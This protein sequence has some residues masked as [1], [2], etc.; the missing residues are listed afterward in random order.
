MY[1]V[2]NVPLDS[3][4]YILWV[5]YDY[6]YINDEEV[7]LFITNNNIIYGKNEKSGF[8][9]SEYK[10]Y[11]IN[12]DDILILNNMYKIWASYNENDELHCVKILLNSFNGELSFQFG[13]DGGGEDA[14]D[15]FM[16]SLIN[17]LNFIH[18]H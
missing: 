4:E 6:T 12:L 13:E 15:G 3:N 17:I 18:H 14:R 9:N 11:K 2:K 7:D 5:G 8:F 1:N 10:F 16:M